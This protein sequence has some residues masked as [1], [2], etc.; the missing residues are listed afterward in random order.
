MAWRP[1]G[2][3][4]SPTHDR[5][6]FQQQRLRSQAERFSRA[7]FPMANT[8]GFR[9]ALPLAGFSAAGKKNGR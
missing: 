9:W 5:H 6:H 2:S 1:R 8:A 4:T 7:L 3:A